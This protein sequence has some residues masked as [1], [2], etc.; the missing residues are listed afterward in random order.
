MGQRED[1]VF[2]KYKEKQVKVIETKRREI[3]SALSELRSLH[4]RLRLCKDAIKDVEQQ[5]EDR[6]EEIEGLEEKLQT[7]KTWKPKAKKKKGRKVYWW[8]F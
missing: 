2:N 3:Y 4:L 8:Y 1:E 6:L 5:M 7:M